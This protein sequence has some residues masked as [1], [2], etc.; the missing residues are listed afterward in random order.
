MMTTDKVL[1][2]AIKYVELEWKF[3]NWILAYSLKA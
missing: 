2:V 3:I 1:Q